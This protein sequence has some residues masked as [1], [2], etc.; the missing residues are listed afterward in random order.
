MVQV[1]ICDAGA[2]CF[3]DIRSQQQIGCQKSYSE[4]AQIYHT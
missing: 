4:L 1:I 3:S 2:V